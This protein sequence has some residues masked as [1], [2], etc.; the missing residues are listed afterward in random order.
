[1]IDIV[2]CIGSKEADS[3]FVEIATQ[4]STQLDEDGDLLS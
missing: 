1:L 4:V 2:I 3:K